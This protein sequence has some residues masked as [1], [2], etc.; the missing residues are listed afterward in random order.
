MPLDIPRALGLRDALDHG[1]P[2][3]VG[4]GFSA[5]GFRRLGFRDRGV[6]EEV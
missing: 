1:V 5:V 3:E 2:E 6:P 4:L